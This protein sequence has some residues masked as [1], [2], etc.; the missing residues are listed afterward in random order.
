[1]AEAPCATEPRWTHSSHIS[2]FIKS[3][4]EAGGGQ[5]KPYRESEGI[6]PSLKMFLQTLEQPAPVPYPT[7]P[8]SAKES[9][10]SGVVM[11]ALDETV[12]ILRWAK[13]E[14]KYRIAPV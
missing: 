14:H 6:M 4:L 1:V 2:D 10:S 7:T 12:M 11:P 5:N 9:P 13:G 8:I 3:L